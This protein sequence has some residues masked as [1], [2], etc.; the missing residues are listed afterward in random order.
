VTEY[1]QTGEYDPPTAPERPRDAEPAQEP[2]QEPAE[3]PS[4]EPG[5]AEG[6]ENGESGLIDYEDTDDAT[7]FG[8]EGAGPDPDADPEPDAS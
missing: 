5:G 3:T 2:A 4:G 8:D 7:S 6:A 1:D